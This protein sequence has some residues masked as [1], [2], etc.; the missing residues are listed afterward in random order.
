MATLAQKYMDRHAAPGYA[1]RILPED[2]ELRGETWFVVAEPDRPDVRYSD[3]LNRITDASMDMEDGEHLYVLFV[4]TL[5]PE[6]D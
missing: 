1:I 6:D 2:V 5:P 3:F 4:P